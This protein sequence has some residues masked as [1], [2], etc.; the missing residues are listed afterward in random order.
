[1]SPEWHQECQGLPHG[2]DR[3]EDGRI[4]VFGVHVTVTEDGGFPHLE[5]PVTGGTGVTPAG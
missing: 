2:Y 3:L 5:A 1:M 4:Y